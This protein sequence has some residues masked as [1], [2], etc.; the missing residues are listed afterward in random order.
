MNKNF[1]VAD[2]VGI[3]LDKV[4]LDLHNYFELQSLEMD[5]SQKMVRISL[6]RVA[7]PLNLAAGDKL[8]LTF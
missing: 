4:Y 3:E 1:V 8:T 2:P 6:V 5:F 7:G